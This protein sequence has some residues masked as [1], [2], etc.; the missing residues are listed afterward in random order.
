LGYIEKGK[1][2]GARLLCGGERIGT[3]GFFVQPTVFSDVAP[4]MAVAREEIFGPVLVVLKFK[5]IQEALAMANSSVYGLGAAVWTSD[6]KKINTFT[7]QVK[8][9]VVWV[10][11]YNIVKYNAPFGGVK[12]TGFGRDLGKDA[13]FE[14]MVSKSVVSK[15]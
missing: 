14:Y 10:N 9:G 7:T 4:E 5:D 1:S 8:A 2:E 13:L 15:L 11:T 3:K 12:Q 6:M